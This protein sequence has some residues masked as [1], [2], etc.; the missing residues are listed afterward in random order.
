MRLCLHENVISLLQCFCIAS[1]F[2]LKRMH[3]WV[4]SQRIVI[5][6]LERCRLVHRS[7]TSCRIRYISITSSSVIC[8]LDSFRVDGRKHVTWS[9]LIKVE[10]TY[11]KFINIKILRCCKSGKIR[12]RSYNTSLI[13]TIDFVKTYL[14]L[15]S[16]LDQ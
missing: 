1:N 16:L 9:L 6:T 2:L 10:S 4:N 5:C 3:L 15:R 8:V 13:K 7:E 11:Q 14:I 12:K